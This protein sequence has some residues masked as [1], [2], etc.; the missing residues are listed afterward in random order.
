MSNKLST[1]PPF[2]GLS[3]SCDRLSQ[4][5]QHLRVLQKSKSAQLLQR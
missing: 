2:L 4:E 5:N 3:L 1:S